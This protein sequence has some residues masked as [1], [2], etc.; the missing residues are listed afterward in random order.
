M[1]IPS[2]KYR[3]AFE[4][5][6]RGYKLGPDSRKILTETP[7]A[8]L[9]APTAV[10][11][12]TIIT[13]LVDTGFYHFI[14]S[15]TTR[16][17]RVNNGILEQS[18]R[19]YF[20]RTEEEVLDD[21]RHGRFVEAAIIHD[22]Q[23]SG[24]SIREIARAKAEGKI[25][26]TD[27]EV[28]GADNIMR[29]KPDASAIFVVPPSFETW[30]GRLQR[31]NPDMTSSEFRRRLESARDEFT[32]ALSRDYFVFVINDQLD[33]AV[34]DVDAVAR[35]HHTDLATQEYARRLIAELLGKVAV[36]LE[37]LSLEKTR[38]P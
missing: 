9:V 27:I 8:V 14:V 11:R 32:V 31:R 23:V 21:I 26:I 5:A 2:L 35:F 33:Q 10:G 24:V 4:M 37:N 6:L 17:P 36:Y 18:G 34:R 13:K 19:E 38:H 3:T 22:Q 1:E 20:F 16:P 30:L 12:N 29:L 15:D 28:V 25:A 7:F